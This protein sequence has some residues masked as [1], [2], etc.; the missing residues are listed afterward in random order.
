VISA[1]GTKYSYNLLQSDT[2]T[3]K[4]KCHYIGEDSSSGKKLGT[5]L[6]DSVTNLEKSQESFLVCILSLSAKKE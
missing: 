2:L 5:I 3:K 6:F 4:T 1:L